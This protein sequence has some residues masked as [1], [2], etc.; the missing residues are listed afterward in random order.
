MQ[1]NR[2]IFYNCTVFLIVNQMCNCGPIYARGDPN[3][4]YR[5]A[6][7]DWENDSN[8]DFRQI[9]DQSRAID[10]IHLR[11]LTKTGI[12]Q[13]VISWIRKHLDLDRL[14]S[15]CLW[16]LRGGAMILTQGGLTLEYGIIQ[17]IFYFQ[18][19]IGGRIW[20]F[21]KRFALIELTSPWKI[22]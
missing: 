8:H 18:I 17:C 10:S 3:P 11:F 4:S 15:K 13:H 20:L 12:H 19:S 22:W 2:P 7:W 5:W 16:T 6:S 1:H 9:V 21:V 14:C